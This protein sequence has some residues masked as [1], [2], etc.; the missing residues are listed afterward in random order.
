MRDDPGCPGMFDFTAVKNAREV[1]M[2]RRSL[3]RD[4]E[5]WSY[6]NRLEESCYNRRVARLW[7]SGLYGWG[8]G[9]TLPRARGQVADY[10]SP[11]LVRTDPWRVRTDPLKAQG[12]H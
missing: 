11:R 3:E 2:K 9:T 4:A 10:S 7:R 5:W 8:E 6:L 12:P 1:I